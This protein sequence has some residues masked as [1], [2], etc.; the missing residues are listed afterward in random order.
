[1][2]SFA[3][4]LATTTGKSTALDVITPMA[5]SISTHPNGVRHDESTTSTFQG[6]TSVVVTTVDDPGHLS[7]L[8]RHKT[9]PTAEE[10]L[11]SRTPFSE[12]TDNELTELMN[13]LGDHDLAQGPLESSRPSTPQRP[14]QARG[15]TNNYGGLC[16]NFTARTWSVCN[17]VE[18]GGQVES[19]T[20]DLPSAG[21][22]ENLEKVSFS[23]HSSLS[24]YL[25]SK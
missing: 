8:V 17:V 21:P 23:A 5:S 12:V 3:S 6:V 20:F 22:P 1:M 14:F 18:A 16:F 24:A 19:P 10:T 7:V 15:D 2:I 9:Q 11:L 25:Q 4:S 13:K